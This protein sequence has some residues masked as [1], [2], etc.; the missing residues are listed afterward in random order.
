MALQWVNLKCGRGVSVSVIATRVTVWA[1][2]VCQCHSYT[3]DN[4]CLSDCVSCLVCA[5]P[6]SDQH[7]QLGQGT[8]NAHMQQAQCRRGRCDQA[9]EPGTCM[10]VSS[11]LLGSW[12]FA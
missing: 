1:R 3:C 8:V 5:D 11:A 4:V 10:S 7:Q 6:W 12:A 2:R 9:S